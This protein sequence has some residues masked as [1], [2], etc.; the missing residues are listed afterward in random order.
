MQ[1]EAFLREIGPSGIA[2]IPDHPLDRC[3]DLYFLNSAEHYA[4]VLGPQ[5]S[6]NLLIPASQLYL[7]LGGDQRLLELFEA[8]HSVMLAVFAAPQNTGLVLKHLD[9]YFDTL[10]QVCFRLKSSS[11]VA[12]L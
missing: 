6:E 10:S 11:R 2:S 4:F 9:A 3:H 8:A 7:G 12:F 5:I 1:A